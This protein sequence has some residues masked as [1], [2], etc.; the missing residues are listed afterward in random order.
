MERFGGN[1]VETSMRRIDEGILQIS[2]L[3]AVSSLARPSN[4]RQKGVK[5]RNKPS[6][7][8]L[9]EKGK[10]DLKYNSAHLRLN[11]KEN[12]NKLRKEC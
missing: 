7:H 1:K 6:S 3:E 8:F 4:L 10:L 2:L 11:N 9:G 12:K 5:N